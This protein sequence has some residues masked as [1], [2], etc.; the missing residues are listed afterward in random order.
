MSV[1]AQIE[2]RNL[3]NVRL[4]RA[5]IRFSEKVGLFER[6][7][8]SLD[9]LSREIL[10]LLPWYCKFPAYALAHFCLR[11]SELQFLTLSR[12]VNDDPILIYQPKTLSFK[13]VPNPIYPKFLN[14]EVLHPRTP[15]SIASYQQIAHACLTA[16]SKVGVFLPPDAHDSTHIFRHLMASFLK[17]N[18]TSLKVIRT[19][20]G[21]KS[22]ESIKHYIHDYKK[23]TEPL[24]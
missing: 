14:L 13:S 20:L 24:T 19:M 23:L 8:L 12:L 7:D 4:H 18:G 3:Y 2:S 16:A 10:A 22:R 9:P 15:F 6:L 1:N 21:H 11:Y 5:L 17:S